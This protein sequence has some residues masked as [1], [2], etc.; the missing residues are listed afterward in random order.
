MVQGKIAEHAPTAEQAATAHVRD[1][2]GVPISHCE[3][4]PLL[5]FYQPLYVQ[6]LAKS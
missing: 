4:E 5:A 1:A 6:K 2:E 3:S